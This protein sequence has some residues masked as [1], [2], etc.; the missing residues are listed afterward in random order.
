MISCSIGLS[1]IVHNRA[2]NSSHKSAAVLI[3]LS[4]HGSP[5]GFP[6]FA[7]MM[8][9]TIYSYRFLSMLIEVSMIWWGYTASLS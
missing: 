9:K 1:G 2:V 3:F 7:A 5:T 8:Q 4:I 6:F